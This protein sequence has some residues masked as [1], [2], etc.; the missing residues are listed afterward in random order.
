MNKYKAA[1]SLNNAIISSKQLKINDF[2]NSLNNISISTCSNTELYKKKYKEES[3]EKKQYL[4]S[5]KN[6][7]SYSFFNRKMNKI[8]SPKFLCLKRNNI[9][10]IQKEANISLFKIN[11]FLKIK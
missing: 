3:P 4:K 9:I 11:I 8:D 1:L 6:I 10:N 7:N 5:S 2:G